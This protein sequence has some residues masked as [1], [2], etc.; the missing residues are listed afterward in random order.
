MDK[1]IRVGVG[2]WTYEPW[3][4]NFYPRG[5][6]PTRERQHASRQLT[7]IE[8]NGTY[9]STMKPATFA[10][11]RDD[12]PDDFVFSLKANK[13]TTNRRVLAEAGESVERF[14]GSG[15]VELGDKLGP[16]LWQFAPTKKF[17]PV[18]F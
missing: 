12:T 17:D 10:K 18:D 16:L 2:G 15:L 1:R 7:A 5:L 13:F 9:Y 4:N 14:I 3:R 11:W 8:V 6:P